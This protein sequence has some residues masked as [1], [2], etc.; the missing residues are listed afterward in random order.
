MQQKRRL[1]RRKEFPIFTRKRYF[2]FGSSGPIPISVVEKMHDY[3]LKQAKEGPSSPG[4]MSAYLSDYVR[5]KKTLAGFLNV[6]KSEIAIT[7]NATEGIN[8]VLRGLKWKK[9]DTIITTEF[10]HAGL[11]VPLQMLKKAYSIK[12]KIIKTHGR[13]TSSVLTDIKRAIDNKT[14][15]IA[16]S[17]VDYV[18]GRRM[19]IR[20]ISNI[21]KRR[22]VMLLVD[23]AQAVGAV[24]VDLKRLGCDFYVFPS[25]KWLLGPH[26]MGCLFVSKKRL[27]TI[28]PVF[29]GWCSVNDIAPSAVVSAHKKT[30]K[31]R[32]KYSFVMD[33]GRFAVSTWDITG[34][35]GFLESMLLFNKF[36]AN[37]IDKRAKEISTL[38][39]KMARI[40]GVSLI[41]PRESEDSAGLISFKINKIPSF[42]ATKRLVSKGVVVRYVP[43]LDCIRSSISAVNSSSD[44]DF[45]LRGLRNVS[46]E[47]KSR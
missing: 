15:L 43:E 3:L 7:Q 5:L 29:T 32:D 16:L 14:R 6:S 39:E 35:K 47:S 45:M 25:H 10:E 8:I 40:P 23:G 36:L 31:K 28:K 30:N 46:K 4:F 13:D 27:E 21:A 20:E 22:G 1:D 26:G 12:V 18:T 11:K 9:S 34:V 44:M 19:P 17:H 42:E 33:A 38:K 41:T 37:D 2:N 24:P